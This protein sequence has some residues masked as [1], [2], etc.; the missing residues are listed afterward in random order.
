MNRL[1]L[2]HPEAPS[3]YPQVNGATRPLRADAA[4]RGDAHGLSLWAGPGH[5]RAE[6]RPAG[7]IVERIA[8]TYRDIARA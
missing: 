1:M 6:A 5:A 2:E 7:E 4:E 3:A 8:D